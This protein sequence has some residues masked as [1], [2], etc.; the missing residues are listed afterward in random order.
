[1]RSSIVWWL[2][3]CQHQFFNQLSW[4]RNL[5]DR[6]LFHYLRVVDCAASK[7]FQ[8]NP[9][10]E[11]RLGSKL[12]DRIHLKFFPTGCLRNYD[13]KC[14]SMSQIHP[15]IIPKIITT[16]KD[17]S[18]SMQPVDCFLRSPCLTLRS[19]CL[20]RARG[21]GQSFWITSHGRYMNLQEPVWTNN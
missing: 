1:M 12:I 3:S 4:C 10:Y 15:K 17:Q 7:K 2:K 13:N 8:G 11:V 16:M 21:G 19:P 20:T 18:K 5:P 14:F 9:S 6:I